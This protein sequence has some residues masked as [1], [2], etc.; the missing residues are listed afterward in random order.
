MLI[1]FTII[2][3]ILKAKKSPTLKNYTIQNLLDVIISE[4]VTQEYKPVL[5]IEDEVDTQNRCVICM[6]PF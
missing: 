4:K 5:K 2:Y 3:F 6:E 1:V